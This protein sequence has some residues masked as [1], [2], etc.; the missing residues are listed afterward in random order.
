[1]LLCDRCY[2][3]ISLLL[4]RRPGRHFVY[5]QQYIVF[6]IELLDK[7]NDLELLRLLEHKIRNW[8][9]VTL[10]LSAIDENLRKAKTRLMLE[11]SRAMA[12]RVQIK[13]ENITVFTI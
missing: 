8:R 2:I 1:V 12:E 13:Q 3:I 5:V 7:T 4:N 10:D 6:L 11:E 9:N